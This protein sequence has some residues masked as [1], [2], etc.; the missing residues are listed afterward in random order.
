MGAN[1][2]RDLLMRGRA[3]AALVR[4]ERR[5]L[6]GLDVEVRSG[7]GAGTRDARPRDQFGGLYQYISCPNYL[8]EIVETIAETIIERGLP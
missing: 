7:V 1:L 2:V 6:A 5:G 4:E 3:V 8:G